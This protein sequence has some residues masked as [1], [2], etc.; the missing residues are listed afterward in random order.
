MKN[1]LLKILGI[2]ILKT[3]DDLSIDKFGWWNNRKI[4]GE[5]KII[6]D[7]KK[8][9]FRNYNFEIREILNTEDLTNIYLIPKDKD[10]WDILVKIGVYS[11]RSQA[12]KDKRYPRFLKDD[13][14]DWI[15]DIGKNRIS[16]FYINLNSC[17]KEEKGV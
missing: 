4:D 5:I 10:F 3:F 1:L 6:M 8:G 12:Q 9:F 15:D 14:W 16:I 7:N 2:K 11:S 17:E 13:D